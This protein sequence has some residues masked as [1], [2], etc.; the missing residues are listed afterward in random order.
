MIIGMPGIG[1]SLG[2]CQYCGK[3]FVLAIFGSQPGGNMVATCRVN[4]NDVAMHE[5]CYGEFKELVD[6]T[7]DW[8]ELP[9]GPLRTA[10]EEAA[11][12]T[13]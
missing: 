4:G 5:T 12:E 8:K 11:Q 9:D 13:A 7:T 3:D 10:F 6:R 1:G 2:K